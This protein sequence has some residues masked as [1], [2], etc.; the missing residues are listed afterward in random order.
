MNGFTMMADSYRKLMNN[1]E[2]DIEN[3][4]NIE[5][6]IRI[7]DFFATCDIDDFCLMVDSSAFN[8]IIRAF[9]K[10]AVNNSGISDKAKEKVIGELSNIFGFK[11]AKE[12]LE[13][14]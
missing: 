11:T 14:G 5:K 9:L 3:I 4:E 13:N 1:G 2:I 8:D 10:M 6:K 7:Y 12:V